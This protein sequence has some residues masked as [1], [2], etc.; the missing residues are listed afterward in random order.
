M[1]GSRRFRWIAIAAVLASNFSGCGGTTEG[2]EVLVSA[3]ASLTDAFAELE[4]SFETAT[5]GVDVVL[6]FGGSA[7]LREQ[8]L[9]G[10]PVDVF[11][12]ANTATMDAVVAAGE[13]AET[14]RI[15]A[16]NL[17]AIAVPP[18]NP[19]GI[20]GLEDFARPEVLIGFCAA[21]VPCGG[22]ARE[23]LSRAGVDPAVDTNEPDV[24]ALLTKIEEGELDAG[25]VYSTDI[26]AAAGL[27]RGITIGDAANIVAEYPMAVLAA[28]PH[29]EEAAAFTAFVHSPVGTAILA[30]HG[31]GTP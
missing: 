27:V 24:R 31:F 13:T 15:F 8:I 4:R 11:A 7:A 6:N 17:L 29:P 18:D 3:A 30:E 22:F 21:A 12:S 23:A 19:A 28:A 5:P 20:V 9:A 25:I 10:A 16:T 14:P 2:T 26:V 1:S